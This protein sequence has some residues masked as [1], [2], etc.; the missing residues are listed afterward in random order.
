MKLFAIALSIT[1]V[2][3]AVLFAIALAVL[4]PFVEHSEA[5]KAAAAFGGVPILTFPKI[6]EFLEQERSRKNLIAGKRTPVYDF[7]GFQIAWPL[8]V[9]YGVLLL[10]AID[11]ISSFVGGL[12]AAG[13]FTGSAGGR[14]NWDVCG[15]CNGDPIYDRRS[16][17]GR[18]VDR[19]AMFA[20]GSHRRIAR[21]PRLYSPAVRS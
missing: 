16:V 1:C 17:P 3:A 12:L 14:D 11:A 19:D 9:L 6:A 15:R 13:V 7:R 8:M 5:M 18:P 2:I 10:A 4:L 20:P 21:D